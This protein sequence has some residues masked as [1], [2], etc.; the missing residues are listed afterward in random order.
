MGPFV[1]LEMLYF[2]PFIGGTEFGYTA[3]AFPVVSPFYG[4]I[5]QFNFDW[6]FGVRAALGYQFV[7]QTGPYQQN[8]HGSSLMIHNMNHILFCFGLAKCQQ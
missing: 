4:K 5:A 6:Q 1:S 2:K 8:I 7:I 3:R